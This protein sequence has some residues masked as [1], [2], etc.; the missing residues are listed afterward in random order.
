MVRGGVLVRM[1]GAEQVTVDQ[2]GADITFEQAQLRARGQ[3]AACRQVGAVVD[4][5][6]GVVQTGRVQ[7]QGGGVQPGDAGVD[8]EGADF[9]IQVHQVQWVCHD[10]DLGPLLQGVQSWSPV[11]AVVQDAQAPLFGGGQ[12]AGCAQALLGAI[13]L[14]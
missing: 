14:Q 3:R 13:V 6:V 2:V 1:P 11:C 9:R 12:W 10:G 5:K 8:E 7:V 4:H